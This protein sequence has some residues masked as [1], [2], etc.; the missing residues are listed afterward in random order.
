M[1]ISFTV[2]L[3]TKAY[4]VFNQIF[5]VAFWPW[6]SLIL[7][8][9]AREKMT[10]GEKLKVYELTNKTLVLATS[11]N[12]WYAYDTQLHTSWYKSHPF[13]DGIEKLLWSD[14]PLNINPFINQNLLTHRT[15]SSSWSWSPRPWTWKWSTC[16][17]RTALSWGWR[18]TA[19]YA[20]WQG[21][22]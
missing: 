11:T 7:S 6:P 16:T 9:S 1:L 3:W 4:E 19:L 20:S 5:L 18:C 2:K 8:L 22:N 17:P 15:L 13:T 10:P 12:I 14:K 21:G